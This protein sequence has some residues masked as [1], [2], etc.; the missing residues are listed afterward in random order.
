M[1]RNL[2]PLYQQADMFHLMSLLTTSGIPIIDN[3]D[4]CKKEFPDYGLELTEIINTI[5]QDG[6]R[7]PV[8]PKEFIEF[9]PGVLMASDFNEEPDWNYLKDAMDELCMDLSKNLKNMRVLF[10]QIL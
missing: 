4:I 3:L 9:E 1:K 5:R 6:E 10:T 2:R 8:E 7:N